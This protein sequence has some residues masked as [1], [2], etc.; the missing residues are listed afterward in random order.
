[1]YSEQYI[2]K[3]L[4][5]GEE[6][7]YKFLYDREYKILCVL[8][9]KY[10]KDRFVAETIVSDIIFSIWLNRE[11]LEIHSSLRSY[12]AR[13]VRNRCLNFLATQERMVSLD[14]QD[15][16]DIYYNES[17]E[18]EESPI[19]FLVE[20]ELDLKIHA[21]IDSMSN[22]TSKIFQESRYNKL[23]YTEISSKL[24]VSVDVVKYHIKI[25]LST[26]RKDLRDYLPVYIYLLLFLNNIC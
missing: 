22:L 6:D 19:D 11:S 2:V 18:I 13:S 24:G 1:M 14:A 4:K 16:V 3:G 21:S 23:R 5:S 9:L 8:A 7:A 26:L 15:K 25:A 10:T 12:L 20:K 17:N